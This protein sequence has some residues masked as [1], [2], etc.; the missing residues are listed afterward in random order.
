MIE[1][2]FDFSVEAE[3]PSEF[4]PEQIKKIQEFGVAMYQ[5]G[6]W[7]ILAEVFIALFIAWRFNKVVTAIGRAR[8]KNKNIWQ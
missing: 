2:F 5:A 4:T 6:E 8:N 3:Q 1:D 7:K